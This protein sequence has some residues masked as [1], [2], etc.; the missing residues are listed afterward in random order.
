[1]SCLFKTVGAIQIECLP[2][3]RR[4]VI[5]APCDRRIAG[6][7]DA[8]GLYMIPCLHHLNRPV[9]MP[10]DDISAREANNPQHWSFA[11]AGQG[12]ARRLGDGV[13]AIHIMDETAWNV[14]EEMLP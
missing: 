2:R 8:G 3:L 13:V 9:E 5:Q 7:S 1:M 14:E 11:S 10:R 4:P 6:I 12:L